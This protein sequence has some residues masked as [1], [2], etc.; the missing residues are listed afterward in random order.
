MVEFLRPDLL[1]DGPADGPGSLAL[2]LPRVGG[3]RFLV[4]DL[5][6]PKID[7]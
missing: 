7:N 6:T 2:L 3:A 1:A 4:R 5:L